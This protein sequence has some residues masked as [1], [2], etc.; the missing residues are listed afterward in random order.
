MMALSEVHTVFDFRFNAGRLSAIERGTKRSAHHLSTT[1]KKA[2]LFQNRVV[3]GLRRAGQALVAFGA[4]RALRFFTSDFAQAADENA[5]FA[6][7]LG[8]STEAYQKLTF[9]AG[10]AGVTQSE[11]NTALPKFAKSAADAADGSKAMADAFDRAGLKL[12]GGKFLGD[13]I[14]MM[15]A[16]ADG[17]KKVKDP[18]RRAQIL[19][20]A[21]GRSGKKMGVLMSGGAEGIKKAMREAEKYGFVLSRKQQKIA[22]DYND[23]MLRT[24]MV[25][26]GLRNQLA[27]KLLPAI[28]K[29]LRGFT[30][31]VREGN[32]LEK[33][34]RRLKTGAI[35]AG[36]AIGAMITTSVLRKVGGFVKGVWAG[37]HAVRALNMASAAAAAKVALLFAGFALVYL[38]IEDLVYFAQGKDSLIGRILGDS[39]LAKDLKT[40]LLDMAKAAKDAWGEIGPALAQSWKELKPALAELGAAMQPLIGPAF[41]GAVQ[42]MIFSFNGLAWA[43][44]I[45]SDLLVFQT[46]AWKGLAVGVGY[47]GRGLQDMIKWLSKIIDKATTAINAIGKLTG[48][49]GKT[50]VGGRIAAGGLAE[51]LN[52]YTGKGGGGA[53]GG[54]PMIRGM[55]TPAPAMAYAAGTMRPPLVAGGGTNVT[56]HVAPGAIPLNVY[57]SGDPRQIA[58][59][60]NDRLD[61]GIKK[62]FTK[63]SRDLKKPPAGQR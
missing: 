39:Q 14:K 27:L 26:T 11:L 29:L 12:R 18:I 34:T 37:V 58:E 57:A 19:Q 5:K 54:T 31:W 20:N 1:A 48:L 30:A 59:A 32:N 10:L 3:G 50:R 8:I 63:A 56:T 52:R 41:R 51:T 47:A 43:I 2:E 9:A 53:A 36:I 46:K 24:K 60:V 6:D 62:A 33:L 28:N 22:E 4:Y 35:F 61:K 23:E 42:L 21:F 55:L 25:F 16:F 13:P 17:L 45:A 38:I 15:T 40:A 49:T 7:G 44:R